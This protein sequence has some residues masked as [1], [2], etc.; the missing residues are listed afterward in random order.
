M[1]AV[2]FVKHLNAMA[3]FYQRILGVSALGAGDSYVEL[4]VGSGRLL[5][6]AMPAAIAVDVHVTIPPELREDAAV[7]LTFPV[8]SLTRARRLA[9][10]NGGGVA[11][12]EREWE[13]D[14]RRYV[15]GWDPEGNVI[16]FRASV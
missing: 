7:K 11:P 9:E 14:G 10:V 2:L 16:Q 5:L 3:A 15:D 13:H 6:H 4:P 8:T 12:E 1:D